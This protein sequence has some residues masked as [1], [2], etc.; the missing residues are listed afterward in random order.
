MCRR[1][2]GAVCQ[3]QAVK[4]KHEQQEPGAGLEIAL[5]LALLTPDFCLLVATWSG[6]LPE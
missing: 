2:C 6:G 5:V 4:I 1:S 3:D